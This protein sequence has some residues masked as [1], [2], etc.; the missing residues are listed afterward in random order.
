MTTTTPT[1]PAVAVLGLGA[2]GRR[3]ALNFAD[4]GHNVTVWNRTL[5]P[6]LAFAETSIVSAARTP[7]EAV[8]GMDVVVSMVAD[9]QASR[10]VWLDPSIGAMMSMAEG[11]VAVESSTIT[12]TMARELAQAAAGRSVAFLEAPVVGSRPQAEAGG[13]FYLVSGDE[14]VLERVRSVVE[15]NAGAI[16]YVG[17]PGNAATMKLAING[18]FGVQVAAYGEIAGLLA[19]SNVDTDTA[20]EVLRGLPI[21]SPALQRILGLYA[22]RDFAPNFPV[23]LVA[24][25][26]GYLTT[27]ATELGA[28]VPVTE[29]TAA[30]Y[31]T[32]AHGPERELDI[33]GIADQYLSM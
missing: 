5:D 14:D 25:D 13:L 30:V 3:I 28:V 11:A 1:L 21:T 6:A 20:I 19:R 31:D 4:A 29:A 7:R 33:A 2:M 24:K 23:H 32:A 9:D 18:L 26:F 8:Q 16:R 15:V 10:E 12:P 22:D 27:V 17:E